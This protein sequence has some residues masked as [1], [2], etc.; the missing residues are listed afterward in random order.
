MGMTTM[1]SATETISTKRTTPVKTATT[2]PQFVSTTNASENATTDESTNNR[3][4]PEYEE[5]TKARADTNIG[6]TFLAIGATMHVQLL[7]IS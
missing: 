1:E 3:T 7:S 4:T 5:I 6:N 2:Q